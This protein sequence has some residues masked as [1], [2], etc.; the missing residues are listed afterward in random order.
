MFCI[1]MR[2]GTHVSQIS[3]KLWDGYDIDSY[4]AWTAE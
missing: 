4:I 1:A 3:P 2:M